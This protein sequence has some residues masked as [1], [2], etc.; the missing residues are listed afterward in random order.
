M[1]LQEVN[2]PVR[3]AYL[4][5]SVFLVFVTAFCS[6]CSQPT[7]GPANPTAWEYLG[8]SPPGMKPKIF[9]PELFKKAG[10]EM[11][12]TCEFSPDGLEVFWSPLG[13]EAKWGSIYFMRFE[14]GKWTEPQQ[15]SFTIGY[16]DNSP[17]FSP[18]GER[19]FFKRRVDNGTM[20]LNLHYVER[21]ADGWST[22]VKLPDAVNSIRINAGVSVAANGDL[23]FGGIPNDKDYYA[24][25]YVAELVD[26][27]YAKATRLGPTVNSDDPVVTEA[28]PYVAKDGSYLLFTRLASEANADLYVSFKQSDGSWGQAVK[29]GSTVSGPSSEMCPWVS[30]DGK[31]LF[32]LSS[33]N[34]S[35]QPYWVDAKII[36]ELRPR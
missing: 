3:K 20:A 32:F 10:A 12:S 14:N 34:G 5:L 21:T 28:S 2:N 19:L 31:Y 29:F 18:D 7:A 25:I 4:A 6:G 27:E 36:E 17:A 26:G 23:Y 13:T 9:A 22:P 30:F 15:P 33:R 35:M 24:D 1:Y 8:Q 11:H 16:Y